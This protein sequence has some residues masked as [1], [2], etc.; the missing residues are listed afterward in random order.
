[1]Y[2]TLYYRYMLSI[3]ANSRK[4]ASLHVT[5]V[6]IFKCTRHFYRI[7][8]GDQYYHKKH[9][10][11]IDKCLKWDTKTGIALSVWLTLV[12]LLYK[13]IPYLLSFYFFYHLFTQNNFAHF[14]SRIRHVCLTDTTRL[15]SNCGSIIYSNRK[16]ITTARQVRHIG[17][18]QI[19]RRLVTARCT[20]VRLKPSFGFVDVILFPPRLTYKTTGP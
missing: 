1:M 14:F 4:K 9:K 10:I 5:H 7:V 13:K 2:F 3:Y 20:I 17:L 15:S 18:S 6:N 19:W 8:Y 11:L 12:R 16:W